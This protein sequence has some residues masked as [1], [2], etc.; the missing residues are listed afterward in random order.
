[1][2]EEKDLDF[3]RLSHETVIEYYRIGLETYRTVVP[4]SVNIS[5]G[6]HSLKIQT[7]KDIISNIC[8]NKSEV[9]FEIGVGDG[10]FAFLLLPFSKTVVGTDI[11]GN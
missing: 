8:I 5:R 10:L 3:K 1:L 2:S 4:K 11:L 7:I 9:V 6:S